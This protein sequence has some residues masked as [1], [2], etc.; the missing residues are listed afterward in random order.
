MVEFHAHCV[1]IIQT[2]DEDLVANVLDIFVLF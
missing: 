1:S 2:L